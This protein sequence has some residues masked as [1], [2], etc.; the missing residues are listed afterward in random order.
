MELDASKTSGPAM[1]SL[2]HSLSTSQEDF[3]GLIFGAYWHES[4]FSDLEWESK[5]WNFDITYSS[6]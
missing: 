3:D 6:L 1:A 4:L 5:D 2:L